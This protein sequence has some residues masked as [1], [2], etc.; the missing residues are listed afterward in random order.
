MSSSATPTVPPPSATVGLTATSTRASKTGGS[1]ELSTAVMN[2]L[3]GM[4]VAHPKSLGLVPILISVT[5]FP[6]SARPQAGLSL[7][8]QVWETS[9]GEGMSRFLAVYY[10][11]YLSQFE[12]T[13][14]EH[15]DQ[16]GYGFAVG[17]IRSGRVGWETIKAFYPGALLVTRYASP[18]VAAQLTNLIT[19]YDRDIKDVNSAGLTLSELRDLNPPPSSSGNQVQLTFS[20][21]APPGGVAGDSFQ[22]IYNLYDQIQWTYDASQGKYLRAQDPGDGSGKLSPLADR[23]TGE[24][25][26]ADNV[27]VL[28]AKHTFVN[29][30]GTILE[31]QL[32]NLKNQH[33]LLFRDGRRYDIQWS[34]LRQTFQIENM[35]GRPVALK[36]GNTFFE[37]VS[38]LSTW[39]PEAAV[40]RFHSPPIPTNTPAPTYTMTPTETLTPPA[41]P[42]T[43]TPV[44][45]SSLSPSATWTPTAT[46]TPAP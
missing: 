1:P 35:D 8:A 34:S 9:I 16:P 31:I 40:L 5:E 25:L 18:E 29:S 23:L 26:G 11:D 21:Q 42:E 12:Q 17:P 41:A 39:D 20:K 19:V 30:A 2:P 3:T 14:Q 37:V 10:G 43:E 38:D 36:P 7:A 24:T 46:G 4:P 44:P 45:S 13:L 28:F 32:L 27:V 15:P 6:P 22:L 33:G